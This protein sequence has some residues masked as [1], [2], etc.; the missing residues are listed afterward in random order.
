M[1]IL[2]I[3][4]TA[5][6]VSLDELAAD[7]DAEVTQGRRFFEQGFIVEG[8]M[9]PTYETAYLIL[10]SPSVEEAQTTLAAYPNTQAGLNT[11]ELFPLIGLPAIAQSL[12]DRQLPFPTWW[13]Q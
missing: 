13:P 6:N 11:W 7:M 9:D 3:T 12:T 8:Y 4:R 10:E 1:R 5:D 2:A